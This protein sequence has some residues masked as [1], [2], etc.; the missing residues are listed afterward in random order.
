MFSWKQVDNRPL[1]IAHRGASA[2]APENTFAAFERAIRQ[3]ADAIELD[4][5]ISRDRELVVIHDSSLRRTTNGKGH[6]RDLTVAELKQFDAGAWFDQP[7]IGERI[8][9]L[10]EVFELVDERVGINI[11]MKSV[12]RKKDAERVIDRSLEIIRKYDAEDYVLLSSFQH[13]LVRLANRLNPRVTTGV[14]YDP[15][16][17][18]GRAPAKLVERAGAAVFVTNFRL[19]RRHMV[20]DLHRRNIIVSAYT[21]NTERS[22]RRCLSLGVQ[23]LVTNKPGRLLEYLKSLK[24]IKKEM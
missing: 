13:S 7:F 18:G 15:L 24:I 5:R 12:R 23:G 17:H 2:E 20:A 10:S 19:L 1:V 21:I 16:R 9:T 4:V 3:G 22:L 6:V 8:P 11:E 14:I